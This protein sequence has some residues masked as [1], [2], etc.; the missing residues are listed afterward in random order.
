MWFKQ[1]H[2]VDA[3][4][5]ELLMFAVW[6]EVAQICHQR[7]LDTFQPSW[8]CLVL[9]IQHLYQLTE[10]VRRWLTAHDVFNLL[11]QAGN[12][13]KT[14]PFSLHHE[15]NK[16]LSGNGLVADEEVCIVVE[17]ASSEVA[18]QSVSGDYG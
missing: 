11:C 14:I 12:R 2:V 18:D 15:P 10:P 4:V 16:Q 7:L 6:Y 13:V 9:Q 8:Y 5:L 3:H 1:H 17:L